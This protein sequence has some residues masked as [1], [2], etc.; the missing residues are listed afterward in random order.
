MASE[1]ERAK[2][3]D[4]DYANMPMPAAQRTQLIQLRAKEFA[5]TAK[6]P[7]VSHAMQVLG[8]M[9]NEAGISKKDDIDGYFQFVGALHTIMERKISDVGKPV[10][11]EEI[12]T[13]GA[14]LLREQ[15]ISK[16]WIWDTRGPA[17]KAEVP[18]TERA[19]II[20]AYKESK[21]FDPTDQVISQIYAAR[22]YNQFYM[23]QTKTEPKIK[24][25]GL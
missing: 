19:K 8:P 17:F 18:K 24:S 7:A 16:G 9:L 12:K 3:L 6:N 14:G 10:P 11:D 23:K 25:G 13:I 21:G 22:Q 1:A 5:K 4:A 2:A 20:E 15:V